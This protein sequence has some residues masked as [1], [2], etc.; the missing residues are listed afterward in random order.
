L[1]LFFISLFLKEKKKKRPFV[2]SNK[3]TQGEAAFRV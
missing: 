1:F 3:Q 2:Q